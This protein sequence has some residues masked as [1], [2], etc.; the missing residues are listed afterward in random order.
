VAFLGAKLRSMSNVGLGA[1]RQE[2]YW[3]VRARGLAV[4]RRYP[5]N[6]LRTSFLRFTFYFLGWKNRYL[7]PNVFVTLVVC[8]RGEKL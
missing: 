6:P 8:T 3:A 7:V 5:K 1:N 2:R 4:E